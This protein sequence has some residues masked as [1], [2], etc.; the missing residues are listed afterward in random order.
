MPLKVPDGDVLG[1]FATY[2]REPR[3]PE[4]EQL[5]MVEAYASIVA[6][7]LDNV[8]HK[9]E[10]AASY[11]AAVLALTSALE[12]ATTTPARTRPRP[13][14][15]CARSARGSACPRVRSR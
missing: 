2:A 9:T 12:S 11:E 14:T 3:R 6:L 4:P 13:R 1:S 8:H 7:G 5:E 10:L 15:W